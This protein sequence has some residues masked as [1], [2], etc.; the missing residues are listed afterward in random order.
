MFLIVAFRYLLQSLHT[1]VS[2]ASEGF[3][4]AVSSADQFVHKDVFRFLA[5]FLLLLWRQDTRRSQFSAYVCCFFVCLMLMSHAFAIKPPFQRLPTPFDFIMLPGF[6]PSASL[7]A[8]F[9]RQQIG[10]RFSHFTFQRLCHAACRRL[11]LILQS[12]DL[13]RY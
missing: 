10:S 6:T 3:C 5:R 4:Q 1:S 8:A 2:H 11:R 12:S 9:L 13:Q 7:T